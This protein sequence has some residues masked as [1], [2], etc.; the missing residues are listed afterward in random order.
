M[1]N[2]CFQIVFAV[3]D[4]FL[5]GAVWT[6]VRGTYLPPVGSKELHA[7]NVVINL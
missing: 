3:A 2:V 6:I 5:E 7:F 4:L 1:I